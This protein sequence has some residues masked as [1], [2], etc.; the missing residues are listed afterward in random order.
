MIRYNKGEYEPALELYNQSLEIARKLGDQL[1]VVLILNN[2]ASLHVSKGE[3]EQ[4]LFHALQ[5]HKI[6]ER[7]AI[8]SE[9]Q[10]SH[11]I[12][13]SIE[14]KLGSEAYQRLVKKVEGKLS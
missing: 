9:L 14:G 7:F 10:K 1:T 8:P 3:Y 13:G 12:L 6:L 5:A 11:D 4:A 2:I